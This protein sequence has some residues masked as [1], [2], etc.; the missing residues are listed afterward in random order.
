MVMNRF[1]C[2]SVCLQANMSLANMYLAG[3]FQRRTDVAGDGVAMAAK[4][5]GAF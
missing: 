5:K 2:C 4:Q 1:C 3:F